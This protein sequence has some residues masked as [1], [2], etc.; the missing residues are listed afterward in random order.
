MWRG[1]GPRIAGSGLSILWVSLDGGPLVAAA[2]QEVLIELNCPYPVV[3]TEI[4]VITD[5]DHAGGNVNRED[6]QVIEK[7]SIKA[8]GQEIYSATGVENRCI[9][10]AH[11]SGA[12]P[13]AAVDNVYRYL[14]QIQPEKKWKSSTPTCTGNS[15]SYTYLNAPTLAVTLTAPASCKIFVLHRVLNSLSL[16][17]TNGSA[18]V[19]FSS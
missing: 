15:I 19:I 13:V 10:Q 12:S 6:Y 3:Q 1:P 7:L 16:N 11:F 5:A 2:S 9:D 18:N 8:S 14:P 17:P 4:R